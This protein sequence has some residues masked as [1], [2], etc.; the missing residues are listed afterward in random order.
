MPDDH[1]AIDTQRVEQSDQPFSMAANRVI[2]A[3]RRIASTEAKEIEYDDAMTG[4]QFRDHIEPEV[5]G[6]RKPMNQYYWLA[7]STAP[8]RVVVDPM[9]GEVYEFTAHG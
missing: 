4:R 2:R 6:S 3:D 8:G 5:A 7:G 1:G 9:S